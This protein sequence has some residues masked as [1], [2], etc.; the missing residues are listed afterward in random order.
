MLERITWFILC[1]KI[2]IYGNK[3]VSCNT[4]EIV[5]KIDLQQ[6]FVFDEWCNFIIFHYA[7]DTKDELSCAIYTKDLTKTFKGPFIET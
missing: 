4:K 7:T 2:L 1:F 6:S 5:A 3:E